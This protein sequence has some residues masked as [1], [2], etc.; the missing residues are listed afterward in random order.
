MYDKQIDRLP[1]GHFV[2]FLLVEHL[3][4]GEHRTE[5]DNV[6]QEDKEIGY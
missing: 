6:R 5:T 4:V 3:E 1:Q 2:H